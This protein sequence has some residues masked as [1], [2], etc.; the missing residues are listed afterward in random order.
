MTN[1]HAPP[2]DFAKLGLTRPADPRLERVKLVRVDLAVLA[3]LLQ[4]DGTYALRTTGWPKGAPIVGSR[5]EQGLTKDGKAVIQVV[6]LLHHPSFPVVLTQPS[7]I[8]VRIE[9][10]TELVSPS[11]GAESELPS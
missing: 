11:E 6:L 5:I 10:L 8:T 1:G 3:A 4:Q 7:E 9:K 2:L